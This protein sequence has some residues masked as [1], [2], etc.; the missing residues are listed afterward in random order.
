MDRTK[1]FVNVGN[2]VV[3]IIVISGSAEGMAMTLNRREVKDVCENHMSSY[4]TGR[5]GRHAIVRSRQAH[6]MTYNTFAMAN[7]GLDESSETEEGK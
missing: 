5:N 7:S 1:I 3:S 4:G 6:Q 2:V